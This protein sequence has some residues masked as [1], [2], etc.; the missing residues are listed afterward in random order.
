MKICYQFFLTI[1]LII[2]SQKKKKKKKVEGEGGE[3]VEGQ[4]DE[5]SQAS[6]FK[7]TVVEIATGEFN[8]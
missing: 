4:N 7:V 5:N 1:G 3:G 2:I 8:L 6:D